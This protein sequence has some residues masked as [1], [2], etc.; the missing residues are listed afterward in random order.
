MTHQLPRFEVAN[1]ES[2]CYLGDQ[3]LYATAAQAFLFDAQTG[4]LLEHGP[5]PEIIAKHKDCVKAY[6]TVG[7]RECDLLVI[8][9]APA[10]FDARLFTRF[11]DTTGFL[12][13]WYGAHRGAPGLKKTLS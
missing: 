5:E 10:Q 7:I 4:T 12:A 3:L 11:V 1:G 2:C 8:G 6:Q 9:F 13:A